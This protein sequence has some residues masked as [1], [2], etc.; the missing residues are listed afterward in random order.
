MNISEDDKKIEI[1][2]KAIIL[3]MKLVQFLDE[4]GM[5]CLIDITKEYNKEKVTILLCNCDGKFY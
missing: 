4:S 3:D 2:Y 5:K 1:Y